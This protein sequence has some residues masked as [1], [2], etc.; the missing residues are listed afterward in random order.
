MNKIDNFCTD[1]T[2]NFLGYF[3][4]ELYGT[5]YVLSKDDCYIHSTHWSMCGLP[6]KYNRTGAV[7]IQGTYYSQKEILKEM[8]KCWRKLKG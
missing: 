6:L 4:P 5:S 8:N 2:D 7:I 3:K 1:W